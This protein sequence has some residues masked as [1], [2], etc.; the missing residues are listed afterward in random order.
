A[1]V[2]ATWSSPSPGD[3]RFGE[4]LLREPLPHEI[5]LL[6]EA[7]WAGVQ[8]GRTR[9]ARELG[10]RMEQ[11]KSR[12][13]SLHTLALPEADCT[14]YLD[15]LVKYRISLVRLP[16]SAVLQP[17]SLR[18]G[19]WQVPV[20]F[21]IPSASRWPFGGWEW[22]LGRALSKACKTGELVHVVASLDGLASETDQSS[23]DRLLR[24]V[25]QYQQ[26]GRL[27]VL[28]LHG[29]GESLM[30]QHR[31]PQGRSVLRAA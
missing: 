5:A 23:L 8:A 19:V 17:Q 12:G 30:P 27:S 7:E 20:S 31:V 16:G 21:H 11:A 3:C 24:V 14:S 25:Q 26:K 2:P 18:F 22:G 13:I 29:L 10:R 9:F 15:L 6:A 28:T 1:R 4:H